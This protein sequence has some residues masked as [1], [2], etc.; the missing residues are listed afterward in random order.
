MKPLI[1]IN[2]HILVA[3]LGSCG[4]VVR[5]VAVKDIHTVVVV[6]Y[7]CARHHES[8]RKRKFAGS[9]ECQIQ[10]VGTTFTFTSN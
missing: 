6:V 2:K 9:A 1:D 7:R 5:L 10:R 8:N 3:T 4:C